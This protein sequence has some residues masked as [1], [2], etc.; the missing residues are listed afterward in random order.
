MNNIVNDEYCHELNILFFHRKLYG[1]GHQRLM[2][3][4]MIVSSFR[5]IV[6]VTQIQGVAFSLYTLIVWSRKIPKIN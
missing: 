4:Q 5:I 3:Q 6:S 1:S 2:L